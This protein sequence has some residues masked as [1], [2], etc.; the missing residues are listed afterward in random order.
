MLTMDVSRRTVL[1]AAAAGGA[2]MGLAGT[3]LVTSG[4]AA[5]ASASAGQR[6]GSTGPARKLR[7]A[8]LLFDGVTAVDA[9]GPCE[10]LCRIPGAEVVTVGRE[11]GRVRT[12]T[13]VL[14]LGVDHTLSQVRTADVLLVPGGNV[15]DVQ[16]DPETIRWIQR[17]HRHTTWTVSVCT[18][19]LVLGAAGLLRGLPATTYWALK[20]ELAQFGATF[21]PS[22]FVEA[23]RIITAAGMS[24]G[25]DMS[26]HLAAKLAGDRIA[27]ALQLVVEYDPQPPFDTGSPD[28]AGPELTSLALRLLRNS[29]A[30]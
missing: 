26:L 29:G 23:G 4:P 22:R 3:G 1:R 19:S 15:R 28:K 12:D 2:G 18:G 7:I 5:P 14:T 24:A 8:I 11:S 27:Q 25:I 6:S 20:T 21:V 16:A 10:V 9:I 17:V 13:G 30:R